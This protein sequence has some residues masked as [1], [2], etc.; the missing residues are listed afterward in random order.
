ML[1]KGNI[2]TAALCRKHIK[3]G[4]I[5]LRLF[6]AQKIRGNGPE[7]VYNYSLHNNK[8]QKGVKTEGGAAREKL[9]CTGTNGK[10]RPS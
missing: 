9:K 7:D 2:F 1:W 5:T 6:R 8:E 10:S 3:F 4:V